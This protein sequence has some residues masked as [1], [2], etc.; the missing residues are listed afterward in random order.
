MKKKAI[1]V[2]KPKLLTTMT[3]AKMKSRKFLRGINLD[4]EEDD[5]LSLHKNFLNSHAADS[6]TASM[7]TWVV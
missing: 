5:Y 1:S 3:E 7:C 2:T 4:K 6:S